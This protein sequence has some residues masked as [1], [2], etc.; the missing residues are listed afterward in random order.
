MAVSEEIDC[1]FCGKSFMTVVELQ[2]HVQA[3]HDGRPYAPKCEVCGETFESPADLK[4]H[5]ESI[6]GI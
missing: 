6:H 2:A 5:N 1:E 3:E 4:A